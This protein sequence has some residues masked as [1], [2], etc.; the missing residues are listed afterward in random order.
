MKQ[1]LRSFSKDWAKLLQIE[2]ITCFRELE[3]LDKVT[4]Y[5][6]RD[7]EKFKCYIE[8]SYPMYTTFGTGVIYLNMLSNINLLDER[9]AGVHDTHRV[10]LLSMFY[11]IDDQNSFT[12]LL[13]NCDEEEIG[14][15]EIKVSIHDT[16]VII[17]RQL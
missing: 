16:D 9:I 4:Q 3:D 13:Q 17:E 11:Q 8:Q 6:Q 7:Y 10:E 1:S 14:A 12:I 2:L 5:I 15:W